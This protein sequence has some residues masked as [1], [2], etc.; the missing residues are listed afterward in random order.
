MSNKAYQFFL[1]L[2]RRTAD[3]EDDIDTSSQ[4]EDKDAPTK[5]RALPLM[6][7]HLQVLLEMF[8]SEEPVLRLV[9]GSSIFEALYI[10][11][12]ASGLGFGSSWEIGERL[13]FRYGI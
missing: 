7:D 4:E 10:F 9:R 12:D 3:A 1:R 8:Q 6:Q 11:G 13:G 5:V 2:G